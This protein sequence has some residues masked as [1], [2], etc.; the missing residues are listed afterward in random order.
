[1]MPIKFMNASGSG[2][3][4]QFI[5]GLDYALTHGA[6][7]SNNSWTGAAQSQALTA[8]IDRAR[9]AGHIFVAA[10]GN[11]ASNNDRTPVYPASFTHDTVVPVAAPD[12]QDHLASFSNYGAT[13]VDLAAP[14]VDILS[15]LPG[16]QYG[17]LSGT[18]MATPQVTGVLALVWAQ[19]PTWSYSQVI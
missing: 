3:V 11:D 10:A 6:K 9:A 16:G 7:I 2:S 1:V 14:G 15:T 8:V 4:S 12:R 17:F 19:H 18:S 13:S 5:A